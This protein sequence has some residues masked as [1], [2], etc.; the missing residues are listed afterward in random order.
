MLSTIIRNL[1]SN[2]LKFSYPKSEI[3]LFSE[4]KG[5]M[6]HLSVCDR[7]I[8]ISQDQQEKL[9]K[10]ESNSSTLGTNKESGTGLGLILCKEF[11]ETNG[12][13]IWLTSEEKK[14]STFTFS[15]PLKEA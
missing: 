14:G 8:G 5:D 9:F 13:K 10:I 2:A 3:T 1:L 6:L 4:I 15:I 12:G 7:G 11:T